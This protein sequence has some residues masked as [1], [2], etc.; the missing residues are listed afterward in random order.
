[1]ASRAPGIVVLFRFNRP[2]G[3]RRGAS[4]G[5]TR[6]SL[7]KNFD[8][9]LFGRIG[10][11]HGFLRREQLEE[12]LEEERSS[13]GDQDL[14]QILLRKGYLTEEQLGMI[15]EIRR[16]KVR[17]MLRDMKEIER[18]ERA[19]GQIALRKARVSLRDLEA[20]ILEQ[21]RLRKMN[22]QF[23]IGEVMVAMGLIGVEDVL[24]ILSEQKKRIL[25][26]PSCDFHYGVYDDHPGEIYRC[27]KC[28][29]VLVEP[30][31]L[32]SVAV[33]GVIDDGA[34]GA[35]PVQQEGQRI[36]G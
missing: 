1:L 14:G 20:A 12:C 24:E 17:K 22:L 28:G 5:L 9:N 31:F 2:R 29:D 7:T 19:F 33:D 3:R 18:N 26:C 13:R 6:M 11:F 8:E 35:S 10:V 32:D 36:G 30:M 25:H 27:R 15:Q 23:R 4:N 21:E 16:K 34:P